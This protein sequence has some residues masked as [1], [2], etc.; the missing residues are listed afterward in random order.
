MHTRRFNFLSS[1]A[2]VDSQPGVEVRLCHWFSF[3]HSSIEGSYWRQLAVH[4]PELWTSIHIDI[5]N[6]VRRTKIGATSLL[7][8]VLKRSDQVPLDIH[9]IYPSQPDRT[10]PWSF[11]QHLFDCVCHESER[12]KTLRLVLEKCYWNHYPI[13]SPPRDASFSM[14]EEV[15]ITQLQDPMGGDFLCA[16]GRSRRLRRL[17][18][19]GNCREVGHVV[20]SIPWS[21]LTELR[22]NDRDIS[23]LLAEILPLCSNLRTFTTA[24]YGW[25]KG[26]QLCTT[27][28]S[29]SYTHSIVEVDL[30]DLGAARNATLASHLAMITL[31]SLRDLR[32]HHQFS[33]DVGPIIDLIE[34]S[35]CNLISLWCSS[36]I[37]MSE[38]P[39]GRILQ[40]PQIQRTLRKLT[41]SGPIFGNTLLNRFF[42]ASNAGQ[43]ATSSTFLPILQ[44]LSIGRFMAWDIDPYDQL[45]GRKLPSRSFRDSLTNLG[46]R[47]DF[48]NGS[49]S[50]WFDITPL[51]TVAVLKSM[52]DMAFTLWHLSRLARGT[53]NVVS[54][55]SVRPLHP[56][57]F[58]TRKS[59]LIYELQPYILPS[60]L[61]LPTD[62]IF[63]CYERNFG[64]LSAPA[65]GEDVERIR[66]L[67]CQMSFL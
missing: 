43:P 17:F 30:L 20:S 37:P 32:I 47:A 36:G 60:H 7:Q 33:H 65:V 57:S 6:L 1:A 10:H 11:W 42:D 19:D 18:L 39:I 44:E 62:S 24:G 66:S 53:S 38:G 28:S 49:E 26:D 55:C 13:I 35:D 8:T 34:R 61:Y 3:C 40:T 23:T 41:I 59:L 16:L 2:A 9:V 5:K 56:M 67:V 25:K 46:V 48:T 64:F 63:K 12:W 54:S 4:T 15:Y 29:T 31:P 51:T 21:Q 27:V 58:R 14:L 45:L 22:L 52:W 50:I